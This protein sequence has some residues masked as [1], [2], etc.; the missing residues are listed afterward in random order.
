M[1]KN[2]NEGIIDI[3]DKVNKRVSMREVAMK[4][5]D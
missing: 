1:C 3:T 5:K 2:D 4:F